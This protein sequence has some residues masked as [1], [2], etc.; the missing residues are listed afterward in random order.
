[1]DTMRFFGTLLN[2]NK[3]FLFYLLNDNNVSALTRQHKVISKTLELQKQ[4]VT[5]S[6]S[7]P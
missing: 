2:M 4:A 1:M 7:M 5:P 6:G 3:S